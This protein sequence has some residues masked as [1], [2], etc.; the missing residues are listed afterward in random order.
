[1]RV[2]VIPVS[3]GRYELYC[4][5]TGAH[6]DPAQPV[7]EGFF[8]RLLRWFDGALDRIEREHRRPPRPVPAGAG[9]VRRLAA[10]LSRRLGRFVAEK[11]AEQRVL[12]RL[13]GR[14]SATAVHPSD[15]DELQAME[16]VRGI[17]QENAGRHGRWL[18]LYA[19]GFVASGIVMPIPGPNLI[20]YYF[21]FLLVGHLLSRLGARHAL[22]SVIWS[23]E[24]NEALLDLRRVGALEPRER[25][26]RVHEIAGRLGLEHLATFFE[27]VA[28]TAP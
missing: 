18:V 4:E 25:A 22:R 2:F 1:M 26:P 9:R 20:A 27:R 23:L 21:A 12:W 13:R 17:L 19:L 8:A 15:L 7:E 16:I 3:R 5:A 28:V 24:P 14:A 10:R 11:V 6:E